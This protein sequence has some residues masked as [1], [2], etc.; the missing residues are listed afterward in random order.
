LKNTHLKRAGGVVQGVGPEFKC[1]Y[2]KKKKKIEFK[3]LLC[4]LL[5]AGI[6]HVHHDAGQKYESFLSI[7]LVPQKFLISDF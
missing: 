1:Q 2:H 6:T 7:I 3:S 5:R 4:H